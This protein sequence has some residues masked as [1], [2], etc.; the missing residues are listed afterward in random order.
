MESMFVSENLANLIRGRE[1]SSTYW[2]DFTK[3]LEA[4]TN[5][6]EK[7]DKEDDGVRVSLLQGKVKQKHISLDEL[8]TYSGM[9]HVKLNSDFAGSTELSSISK[10]NQLTQF[11]GGNAEYFLNRTYK[12][13]EQ[14][15]GESEPMMAIQGKVGIPKEYEGEK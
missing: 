9:N 11:T 7:E 8:P 5:V 12:G 4:P 1:W 2:T 10:D 6:V 13:L 15:L 3:V 14:K